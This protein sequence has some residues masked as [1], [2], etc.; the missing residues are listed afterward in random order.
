MV[1]KV[2]HFSKKFRKQLPGNKHPKRQLFW[3]SPLPVLHV[4][5]I[6]VS[7]QANQQASQKASQP[8]S[9][10]ASC[11]P[12]S[13]QPASPQLSK[14]AGGRGEALRSAAPRSEVAGRA[15]HEDKVL[16]IAARRSL[17]PSD[18]PHHCR[19]PP[20]KSPLDDRP[21]RQKTTSK[22][23]QHFP[24]LFCVFA[25]LWGPRGLH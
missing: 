9:R 24:I 20:M 5:P 8:A 2:T 12:A 16:C 23:K 18:G 21:G 19:Q 14:G 6:K 1:L 22:F 11:K 13:Q 17:P 4:L 25:R 15:G 7:R 10:P 3:S